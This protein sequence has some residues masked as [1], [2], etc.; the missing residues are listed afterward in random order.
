MILLC[1]CHPLLSCQLRESPWMGRERNELGR[2]LTSFTFDQQ[3]FFWPA[4]KQSG[5]VTSVIVHKGVSGRICNLAGI[6]NGVADKTTQHNRSFFF[7]RPFTPFGDFLFEFPLFLFRFL[8]RTDLRFKAHIWKGSS[9]YITAPI[10]Q[11][12]VLFFLFIIFFQ[13]PVLC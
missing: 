12:P 6:A 7:Y 13:V 11:V 10:F 9:L 5:D 8:K 1:C 4:P 2:S 3:P